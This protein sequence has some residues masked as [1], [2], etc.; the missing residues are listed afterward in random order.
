MVAL[1]LLTARTRTESHGALE[2]QNLQHPERRRPASP[3]DKSEAIEGGNR[4]ERAIEPL[5]PYDAIRAV[6]NDKEVLTFAEFAD[7]RLGASDRR[8][9][10]SRTV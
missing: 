9:G 10:A 7:T 6:V 5:P 8:I 1:E 3:L 2:V 4:R